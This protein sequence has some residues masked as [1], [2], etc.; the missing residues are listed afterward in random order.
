MGMAILLITHNLGVVADV[1]DRVAV[2]YAGQIVET[3]P[4]E[5]LFRSPQHPYTA[6]L[7]SSLPSR[8]QRGRDLTTLAGSVPS[9]T[10]WPSGCRFADR[11]PFRQAVCD[12]LPPR[13]LVLGPDSMARCHLR[14]PDI[15][16]GRL[17]ASPGP[18]VSRP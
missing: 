8:A 5:P 11:C 4:T 3:A 18:E 14:D 13:P 12:A 7:L 9:A 15:P 6:A 17:K 1:A 10:A 16:Q 2:M